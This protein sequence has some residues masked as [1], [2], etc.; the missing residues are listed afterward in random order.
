MEGKGPS[1]PFE[2]P[3]LKEAVKLGKVE[4]GGKLVGVEPFGIQ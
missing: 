3:E 1:L 4:N 2:H